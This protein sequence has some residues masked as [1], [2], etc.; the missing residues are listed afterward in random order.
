MSPI[1][2]TNP[3]P[4][5]AIL[6]PTV[7]TL[8]A[9]GLLMFFGYLLTLAN[10]VFFAFVIYALWQAPQLLPEFINSW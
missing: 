9:D 8:E 3:P 7:A 5:I 6:F 4:A 1:P 2:F 10:T